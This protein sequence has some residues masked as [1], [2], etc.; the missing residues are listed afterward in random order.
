MGV[1]YR[2]IKIVFILNLNI[3]IAQLISYKFNNYGNIK[4]YSF[5]DIINFTVK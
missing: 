1:N 4:L 2:E 3:V 5:S